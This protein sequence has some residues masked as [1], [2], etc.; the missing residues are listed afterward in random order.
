[1]K[2]IFSGTYKHVEESVSESFAENCIST[3]KNYR[4][5]KMLA[6]LLIVGSLYGVYEGSI[7]MGNHMAEAEMELDLNNEYIPFLTNIWY[8]HITALFFLLSAITGRFFSGKQNTK[9][10]FVHNTLQTIGLFFFMVLFLK[11]G[12]LFV[13]SFVV[14]VIY[15][16]IFIG[17]SIFVLMKSYQNAVKR[18]MGQIRSDILMWIG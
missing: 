4:T 3:M 14:R 2:N 12:Q 13:L 10:F 8:V 17:V 5:F 1:M 7:Y 18:Y 15:A 9:G 11:L 6:Y 16:V